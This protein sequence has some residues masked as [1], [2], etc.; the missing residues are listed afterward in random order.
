MDKRLNLHGQDAD[1]GCEYHAQYREGPDMHKA[2]LY[3][4][5][6]V[7]FRKTGVQQCGGNHWADESGAVA[8]DHHCTAMGMELTPKA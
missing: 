5:L 6:D 4:I 7:H 3:V 8:A 2:G 1:Y